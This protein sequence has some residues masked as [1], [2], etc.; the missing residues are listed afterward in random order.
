MPLNSILEVELFDVWGIDFMGPF[1]SSF[2]NQYILV[3]V[4][5]VSKW[6]EAVALPTND[7]RVVMDFL[8]KCIFTRYGTPRAIIS[9][10]GKHFCNR[11]F[12]SLL[13]K[14]GVWHRIATHY[15]PQTSGLQPGVEEDS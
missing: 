15:H 6:V 14:Y 4:D 5:Y 3:V 8:K 2:S 10:G 11:Q 7:A 12:E 1:P 9:D 13:A